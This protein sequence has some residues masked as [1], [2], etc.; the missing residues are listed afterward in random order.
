MG[1]AFSKRLFEY[2]GEM[3]S[4]KQAAEMA[5]VT[6]TAINKRLRQG[7]GIGEIID[8]FANTSDDRG[9]KRI[10]VKAAKEKSVVQ[11]YQAAIRRYCFDCCYRTG[12]GCD[13]AQCPLY[14]VSK[15]SHAE[16]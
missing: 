14:A 15:L 5:G 1:N 2:R 8:Y 9:R 13:N 6:V 3:I 16:A 4:A 10:G 12:R 11:Q 7:M